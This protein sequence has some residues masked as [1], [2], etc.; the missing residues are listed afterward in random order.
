ML[1]P[2]GP[3]ASSGY[4]YDN[5]G[6]RLNATYRVPLSNEDRNSTPKSSLRFRLRSHVCD[7]TGAIVEYDVQLKSKTVE[8]IRERVVKDLYVTGLIRIVNRN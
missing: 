8:R 2:I 3:L 4:Y 7:L 1:Y 5:M 6:M